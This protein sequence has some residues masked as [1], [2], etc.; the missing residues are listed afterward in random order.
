M[1]QQAANPQ[2]KGKSQKLEKELKKSPDKGS[3]LKGEFEG[4][5]KL[6]TGDYRVIYA[7]TENGILILRVAHRKKA[8]K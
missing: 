4:H 1:I 7:K 2:K 6:R 8:Y 5:F 3:P